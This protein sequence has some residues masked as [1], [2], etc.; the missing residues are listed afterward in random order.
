M[1]IKG[2]LVLLTEAGSEIG[3]SI[4]RHLAQCGARLILVDGSTTK[5]NTLALE[6]SVF[7][8]QGFVLQAD[9]T[10]HSGRETIRTA[11][12]ALQDSVDI[13]IHGGSTE[14][15]GRLTNNDP[16]EIE[17]VILTNVTATILLTRLVIPSL[18]ESAGRI[19]IL[20]SS[21]GGVGHPGF[22]VYCASQFALRGFSEALR[23]EIADTQLQIAY[24]A[25]RTA[26]AESPSSSIDAF[27]KALGVAIDEPDR[28]AACVVRMLLSKRM[29]DHT[30][31][32][33]ES[34]L[35]RINSLFPRVV[36]LVLRNRLLKARRFSQLVR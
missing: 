4:A 12:A 7:A 5:L 8:N 32:W 14:L 10:T 13:L 36:D 34:L 20:G 11:L 19:V 28:V 16:G 24:L 18:D 35:L 33:Q 22:A 29:R 1:E 26:N 21:L 27:N 6:L 3:R 25:T 31:G 15:F 23:R 17:R 9:V 30:M 2:K